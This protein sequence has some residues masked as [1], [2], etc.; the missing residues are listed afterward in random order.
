MGMFDN[1]V[2]VWFARFSQPQSQPASANKTIVLRCER[3]FLKMPHLQASESCLQQVPEFPC[4]GAPPDSLCFGYLT[5]NFRK[6]LSGRKF[7]RELP[8]H[9]ICC[10]R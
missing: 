2:A 3:D 9:R 6:Q 8:F 5:P 7:A 10:N 1:A 4:G